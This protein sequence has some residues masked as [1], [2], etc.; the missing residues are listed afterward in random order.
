VAFCLDCG[1]HTWVEE[2]QAVLDEV[3][4]RREDAGL[5]PLTELRK[6]TL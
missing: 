1:W 2:A 4:S 5:E 6:T 3:N